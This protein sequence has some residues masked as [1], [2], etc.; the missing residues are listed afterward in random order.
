MFSWL[1]TH[2]AR[3]NEPAK[4]VSEPWEL[5]GYGA[6][7][8]E[9]QV[10]GADTTYRRA[11]IGNA[12]PTGYAVPTALRVAEYSCGEG[13]SDD[14]V[15]ENDEDPLADFS[16]AV[17]RRAELQEDWGSRKPYLSRKARRALK[18]KDATKRA[19]P[20]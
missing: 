16:D 8:P 14:G 3:E 6:P 15:C 10:A 17:R 19:T 4:E 5:I 13:S 9:R 18:K 20:K 11:A 2:A 1:F 7:K 12:E